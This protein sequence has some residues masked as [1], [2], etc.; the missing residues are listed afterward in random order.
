MT[1]QTDRLVAALAAEHAA[2]FAYSRLGPLLDAGNQKTARTADGAHH[3]RRDVLHSTLSELKVTPPASEPGYAL[4]FPVSDAASA[5][6][7]A[8]YV[9]DRVAATWRAA[10]RVTD[11]PLRKIALD[12]YT[13]SV[14]LAIRWRRIAGE[15]DLTT[16]FPG[17]PE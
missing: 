1:E 4:P 10:L 8:A 11:G 3:D 16:A 13:G 15:K 2:L 12:A 5:L 17:R 7:L 9:E 14:V 6:K